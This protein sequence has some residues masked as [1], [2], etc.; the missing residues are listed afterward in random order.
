MIKRPDLPRRK[1]AERTARDQRLGRA[2]R[3]N[4]RRRK[5]QSRAREA[6]AAAAA[7]ACAGLSGEPLSS[8]TDRDGGA[9]AD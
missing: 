8:K 3:D 9:T 1:Q 6:H 7:D 2:L 4:L 5:E